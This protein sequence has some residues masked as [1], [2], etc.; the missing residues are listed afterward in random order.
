MSALKAKIQEDMKD[1]MRAKDTAR[2]S[3]IRMIWAELRKREIDDRVDLDD[4][5]IIA[6]L[7]KMLKQRQESVAQYRVANRQDLIDTEEGEIAVIRTYLPEPL[8]EAEVAALV[9]K[10][11]K[12][13]NIASIKDMG[14][15]MTILREQLAG[16]ADMAKVGQLLK[17]QLA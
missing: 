7:N 16:R 10:V 6:L 12:E 13:Q 17:E 14:R 4:A 3:A 9:A 15:A 2:L 8:G 11:L 5:G 1:A